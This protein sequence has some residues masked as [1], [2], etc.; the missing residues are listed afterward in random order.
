MD[1]II[2]VGCGEALAACLTER[3]AWY[4]AAAG[5]RK[6]PRS[7]SGR[8]EAPDLPQCFLVERDE[9][10]EIRLGDDVSARRPLVDGQPGRPPGAKQRVGPR[11]AQQVGGLAARQTR[12]CVAG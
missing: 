9:A 5:C 3:A 11:I 10:R 1:A 12:T 2:Q 8:G 4:G 6:R 7:A